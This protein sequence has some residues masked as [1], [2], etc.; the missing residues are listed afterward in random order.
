MSR[1][2]PNIKYCML[3][4]ELRICVCEC[5][6]VYMWRSGGVERHGNASYWDRVSRQRGR[7]KPRS[8][9]LTGCP[10]H[11]IN[12]SSTQIPAWKTISRVSL[13]FSCLML[14][15]DSSFVLLLEYSVSAPSHNAPL[16][17]RI[18]RHSA[19]VLHQILSP[20]FQTHDRGTQAWAP[21]APARRIAPW[22]PGVP[23]FSCE[24]RNQG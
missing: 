23:M 24:R 14:F 2:N 16:S 19:F 12:I 8:K 6:C 15:R 11:F 1:I 10:C 3:G 13:C 17:L 5:V 18:K 4:T 20:L 7:E 9:D 21:A 22:V